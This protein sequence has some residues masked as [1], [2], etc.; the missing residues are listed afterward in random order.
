MQVSADWLKMYASVKASVH[1]IADRLTMTVNEVDEIRSLAGLRQVV[2]GE[3]TRLERH[4]GA[5]RLWVAQV[6]AGRRSYQVVA[7]ADNLAVGEKV[8]LAKPGVT[9]PDGLKVATRTL[10]GVPSEGMLCS[11]RELGIGED[12]SGIWLLPADAAVGQ[13]LPTA[14]GGRVDSFELDVPANRPDLMGHLGIAREVAAGFGVRFREPAVETVPKRPRASVAGYQVKIQDPARCA[15][16]ALAR[17]RGLELRPSPEW[18]QR[19]LAAVGLRPINAVVDVTN[20]VMLEYGQP[21]HAYD[22]D[23][24]TGVVVYARNSRPRE[25]I[26]TLDGKTRTLPP[27][28]LVIADRTQALGIAGIM[29]GAGSEVSARTT[30]L[31]LEAANF[32]GATIRRASRQLGLRTDASARFEKNL[33]AELVWPALRRALALIMEICGG[34]LV[35][36]TDRYPRKPPRRTIRLDRTRLVNQLGLDVPLAKIRAA[37]TR[38]GFGAAVRGQSLAV[39][40]P[41]WRADVQTEADLVEEVARTIGY[42]KLP[43]T[44]PTARLAV[45]SRPPLAALR[46]KLRESLAGCGL[47][48]ILTHSLVGDDLLKKTGWSN[49]D[50]VRMANPLS[51]D[52]AYLRGSLG[53]R[54]LEAVADNLRWRDELGLFEIGTTFESTGRGKPPR[55]PSKLLV[56]LA[57]KSPESR[58][59]DARGALHAILDQLHLNEQ[60]L[61]FATVEHKQFTTDFHIRYRKTEIGGIAE[62]RYPQ[63][64]KAGAIAILSIDLGS[65]ARIL[66]D[67][68]RVIT[69][70]TFPAVRRDLSLFLPDDVPYAELRELIRRT[71]GPLLRS[72]SDPEEFR[73]GRKRSLTVRLAFGAAD[74]TLT[75]AEVGTAMTA[76]CAAVRQRGWKVRE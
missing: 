26:K 50:L 12:H 52:H 11:P 58:I 70:P 47:T 32:D 13:P 59:E 71:A 65:L 18:L 37:L 25:T 56:T 23:A 24:L 4:P 63:R 41:Y 46:T 10:R 51:A 20:F 17:V 29:G 9:L 68:W 21:L 49:A 36:L 27:G 61:S 53:P 48:E 39:T 7:G 1:Q 38:L 40:P 34:E 22:A 2:V 54:H 3:V 44:L 43:S 15:R 28:A 74:R 67:T 19:R 57:G 30:D 42:D 73:K 69:P 35:Q 75:D 72:V 8:P 31:V 66:P 62:Y 45:P 16:F 14:L 64:F 6:L 60:S 5:D 76:V 33:P 55:E